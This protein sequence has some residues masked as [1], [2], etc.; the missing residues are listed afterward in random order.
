MKRIKSQ[1]KSNESR[2]V[3]YEKLQEKE[4]VYK[5]LL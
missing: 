2:E 4:H 1:T 3:A 5:Y